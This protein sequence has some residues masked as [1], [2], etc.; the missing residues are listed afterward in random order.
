MSRAAGRPRIGAIIV[1]AD[2]RVDRGHPG[3]DGTGRSDAINEN[4]WTD[5]L[6]DTQ[7]RSD[8]LFFTDPPEE[9]FVH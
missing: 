2:R 6:T 3:P 4:A 5:T 8:Q 1:P 7:T 9:I